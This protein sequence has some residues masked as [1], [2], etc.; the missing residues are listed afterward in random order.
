MTTMTVAV[1]CIA[2][3]AAMLFLLGANVSRLR[4]ERGKQGGTQL[5]TDPA[6]RLF[7]AIRAHGNAS[8]YLP[9]L[10]VLFLLLAWLAPGW[11]ST[12][13]IIGATASRVLHAVSMLRA[14]SMATEV[15]PRMVGAFGT[16]GFGL[17]LAVTVAVAGVGAASAAL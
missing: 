12:A 3:L 8:E 1:G 2:L 14:R 17:A 13:L 16:F 11:W 10:M 6:D 5:P 4:G 7:I 9:T 15:V